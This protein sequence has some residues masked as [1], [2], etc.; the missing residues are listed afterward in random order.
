MADDNK[1]EATDEPLSPQDLNDAA[2][3]AAPA[4]NRMSRM[5]EIAASAA[6][7][8][9]AEQ[10]AED[11]TPEPT[12]QGID[13]D[14]LARQMLADNRSTPDAL[15][16]QKVTIKIDGVE[17]ERTIEELR[18]DAQIQGAA[19]RRLAEANRL[20]EQARQRELDSLKAVSNIPASPGPLPSDS[21]YL[22]QAKDVLSSVFT[23][24][25]GAA[26]QK[27]AAIFQQ[28]AQPQAAL[29]I[30]AVAEAA[31]QRMNE[32][33]VLKAF[34]EKYPKIQQLNHLQGRTDELLNHFTGQGKAFNE[35]L[36]E[37]GK[38]VYTELGIDLPGTAALPETRNTTTRRQD[39][40]QRKA[41]LDVPVARTVSSAQVS[42]PELSSEAASLSAI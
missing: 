4:V 2:M 38:A 24:D 25:E 18:R 41:T 6:A 7:A 40:A 33:V 23:G 32:G 42:T 15:L 9:D 19:A 26:A 34:F 14:Q 12:Q 36:E 17:E 29:D 5:D 27:L 3:K 13:D 39:L 28:A 10:A 16:S 35:A 37:A 8:R 21:T 20:L 22:D 31:T 1:H 30:N 11:G